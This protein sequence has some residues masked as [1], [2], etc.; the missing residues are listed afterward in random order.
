[1]GGQ[2]NGERE[3]VLLTNP[4]IGNLTPPSHREDLGCRRLVLGNSHPFQPYRK[5]VG[6]P[7]HDLADLGTGGGKASGPKDIGRSCP[8]REQVFHRAL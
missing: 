1:M 8:I 5:V 7:D 4:L 6:R 2:Q 3:Q